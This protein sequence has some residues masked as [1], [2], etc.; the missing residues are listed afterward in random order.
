MVL[1]L[2]AALFLIPG[3]REQYE[4]KPTLDISQA[5]KGPPLPG[6][7]RSLLHFTNTH[8]N[9]M[10]EEFTSATNNNANN[11]NDVNLKNIKVECVNDDSSHNMAEVP[12]FNSG[13][14]NKA[15]IKYES[16]SPNPFGDHDY[17]AF[18]DDDGVPTVKREPWSPSMSPQQKSYI[19]ADVPP[20]GY[21]EQKIMM[22]EEKHKVASIDLGFDDYLTSTNFTY[23]NNPFSVEKEVVVTSA[24]AE[25]MIKSSEYIIHNPNNDIELAD[26][27]NT[28]FG[29]ERRLNVSVSVGGG[30]GKGGGMRTVVLH[31]PKDIQ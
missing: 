18:S 13:M 28:E 29:G 9:N 30:I 21:G 3:M 11:I 10:N 8:N 24:K 20:M 15:S 6:Q 5:V 14:P 27:N 22:E 2:S 26:T 25:K 12:A 19:D 4:S 23:E 7:S 1:L 17:Y 31:V 16:S